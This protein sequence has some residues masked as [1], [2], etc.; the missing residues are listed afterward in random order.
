MT[1]RSTAQIPAK[2]PSSPGGELPF[3]WSGGLNAGQFCALDL[4][5]DGSDDLVLFD[6]HG[7]RVVPFLYRPSVAGGYTEAPKYAPLLP[8]MHDWF[9]TADYDG[10]GRKDIFTY[11]LGGIRVFRNISV[12]TL[13]FRNVTDLLESFYYTGKVGILVTSVDYPAIG[14]I[15]GDGDLD[16]LTFIS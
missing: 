8:V 2:L 14:D 4:D 9:I 16:L 11:G 10:D 13:A 1:L 12:D 7:N 15:D 5:L 3:P 6:R